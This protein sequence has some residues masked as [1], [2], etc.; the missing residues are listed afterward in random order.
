MEQATAVRIAEDLRTLGVREGGVLLMHSS[1]KSLGLVP[2]GIETVLAGLRLA[3][4]EQGTLLLPGLCWE[5]VDRDHTLFDVRATPTCVGAIPEYFRRLPATARSLHPTHSVLG[6]GPLVGAFF[7]EHPL[8][9]TPCGPHSPFARLREYGGQILMLGC[10]LR[11][12]TSMHAVEETLGAPYLFEPTPIGFT[13]ADDQGRRTQASYRYHA[14]FPQNY[15]RVRPRL[16][17]R[18]L[19][20]GLV[21]QAHC[22][23]MDAGALWHTAAAMLREDIYCF[24]KE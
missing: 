2:G 24:T 9:R 15:D 1:L 5:Y 10:G 22:H 8:D 11:P 14:M 20:E 3:L 17:G 23:L 19:N 18:G 12:N 4:G 21:L 7:A 13:L 6:Q 16:L